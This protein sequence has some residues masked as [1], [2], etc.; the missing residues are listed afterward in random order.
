[1]VLPNDVF[2]KTSGEFYLGLCFMVSNSSAN[3][4]VFEYK[5]ENEK[6]TIVFK[7]SRFETKW[8]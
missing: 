4:Y 2:T 8:D 3:Y 7:E 6:I 5:I 1:M